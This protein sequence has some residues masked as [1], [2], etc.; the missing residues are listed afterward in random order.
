[1]PVAS[2]DG[3]DGSLTIHQD[4]RLYVTTLADGDATAHE[5]AAG[6]HAWIHVARGEVSLGGEVLRAGDA[7]RTSDA[8]RLELRGRPGGGEVLLFDLA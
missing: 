6:R 1:M 8:G 7:A 3:A 4:A 5:L 2:P